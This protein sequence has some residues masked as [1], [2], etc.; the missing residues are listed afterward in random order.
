MS[1]FMIRFSLC[2]IFICGIIGILLIVKRIFKNIL[3]NRMQY[4]LWFL[5]LGLLAVPFIP[6][7]SI[8]IL[9]LLS[10]AYSFNSSS[11]ISTEITAA[12]TPN[13]NQTENSD[14]MNDFALSVNGE[15]PAITGYLLLSIWI[16]G[17]LVMIILIIKSALR[18]RTLEKSALP[19]QNQNV[20]RLYHQC[21]EEMEIHRNIPIYSTA[22]IK[23][24][25]TVGLIRPRIYLPI[26]LISDYNPKDCRFMLLHELQHY[27]HGDAF[28]NGVMN[29]VSI[30]YWFNPMIWYALKEMRNDR[31]IACDSSVLN[32][33]K[34]QDYEEYGK[35]LINFA[36]KL[37]FSAFPFVSNMGGNK[38]QIK[39]RIISIAS[40][41]STTKL[42]TVKG[43][44]VYFLIGCFLL[45]F[46]PVLTA[47]ASEN[48]YHINK[49]DNSIS[50]T[51]LSA[52]FDEYQGCFVLF[53][54]S[55]ESW[56]IYNEAMAEKRISPDSTCKI[57]NAI[58]A[59]ENGYITPTSNS[60]T[61]D[62]W[63][64]P[65]AEW[66]TNQNLVTAFRNS[67]NWY[68]QTLDQ[69]AGLEALDS[70]Y[71]YIDYGNHDLSAGI[72]SYWAESSLKISPIEQVEMLKRLYMNEFHFDIKNVHAVKNALL[73]S[74][75]D[76]GNLYGKTGTGNING[77]NIS[78]WFI[79]FIE[80]PNN[81]YFFALNISSTTNATGSKASD[82]ALSILSDM[83]IW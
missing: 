42:Q 67:V 40:Y 79:G 82:I 24:P 30:V 17:I 61:W 5:L 60:M 59:L 55:T 1:D 62:G 9:Q 22:Y 83:N 3:S 12:G 54:L 51:D 57:Y 56:K 81:T 74:S 26:H 27:K 58:F 32:M 23:S 48:T 8:G 34:E 41:H 53:D 14:W 15:R 21:L 71:T 44:F 49:E 2:N 72:S 66:N 77:E 31:E 25:F 52:Y 64:Y 63:E 38:Q 47:N 19:L 29:L 6:F 20:R 35:T 39:K 18:L 75:N 46:T 28:I 37:S 50:Y 11:D 43:L 13:A 78:G 45:A 33:L 80:T 10:W 68:F 65:I 16:V 76:N 70:F 36:E 73:L 4:N 7:R 69:S